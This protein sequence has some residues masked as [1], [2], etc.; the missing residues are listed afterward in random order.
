MPE[1]LRGDVAQLM[2][3]TS[4]QELHTPLVS[5][6]VPAVNEAVFFAFIPHSSDVIFARHEP[7]SDYLVACQ[8]WRD[9]QDGLPL[10]RQALHYLQR[11]I[12]K[13]VDGT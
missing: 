13:A 12:P 11:H 6:A 8:K 1:T 4:G 3:L 10:S 2:G 7:E 9:R 5:Y